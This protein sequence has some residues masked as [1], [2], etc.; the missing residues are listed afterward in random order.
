M[1]DLKIIEIK[2]PLK[3]LE[4][5]NKY[6]PAKIANENNIL[7]PK[8][9]LFPNGIIEFVPGFVYPYLHYGNSTLLNNNREFDYPLGYK[10]DPVQDTACCR[11]WRGWKPCIMEYT[12]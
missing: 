7:D 11:W 3:S 1:S 2:T 9:A 10:P 12:I 8:A 4:Q 6:L 5:P